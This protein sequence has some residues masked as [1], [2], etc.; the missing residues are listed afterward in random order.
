MYALL[1]VSNSSFLFV[2][3]VFSDFLFILFIDIVV[4]VSFN[5]V[6]ERVSVV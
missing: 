3:H 2:Q 6:A 1:A 5:V 4:D